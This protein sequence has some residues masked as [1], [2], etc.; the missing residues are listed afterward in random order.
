MNTVWTKRETIEGFKVLTLDSDCTLNFDAIKESIQVIKNRNAD[1]GLLTLWGIELKISK[2]DIAEDVFEKFKNIK[3]ENI[4]E[5][6]QWKDIRLER[7]L[8]MK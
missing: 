5:S 6:I 2:Y 4:E 8:L 3:K 1:Y 7:K